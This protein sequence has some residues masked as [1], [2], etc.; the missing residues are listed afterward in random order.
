MSKWS[1][2]L[3]DIHLSLPTIVHPG[4]DYTQNNAENIVDSLSAYDPSD[5]NGSTERL[6]H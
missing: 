5:G 1:F 3:L 6:H 2:P 4:F